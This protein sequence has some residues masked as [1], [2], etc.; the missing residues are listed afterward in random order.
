MA[1]IGVTLVGVGLLGFVDNPLVGKAGGALIDT[2]E[3]HSAVH[4]ATGF[5]ALYLG[6]GLRDRHVA[7]GVIAFGVV[8]GLIFAGAVLSPNVFGLF[9]GHEAELTEH[10]IHGLVAAISVVVGLLGRAEPSAG[11]G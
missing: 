6:F 11:A 3:V 1:L 10:A 9:G 7:N 4:L 5:L 8:Y 2:N